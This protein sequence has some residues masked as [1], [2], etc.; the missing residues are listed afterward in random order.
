MVELTEHRRLSRE[1]VPRRLAEND[2]RPR[3]KN[4]WCMPHVDADYV[5]LEGYARSS[6]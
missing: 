2:L 4:M 6:L 1:T 5:V 3:R